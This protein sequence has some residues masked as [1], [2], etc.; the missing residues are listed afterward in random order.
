M[1]P[2]GWPRLDMNV[3]PR[4]RSLAKQVFLDN[5]SLRLIRRSFAFLFATFFIAIV[6]GCSG[7]QDSQL[8][9]VDPNAT[10]EAEVYAKSLAETEAARDKMRKDGN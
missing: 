7:K 3:A 6:P 10:E 1:T 8:M 9:E 4:K 5:E 2:V